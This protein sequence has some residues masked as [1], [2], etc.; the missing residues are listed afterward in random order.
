MRGLCDSLG[1]DREVDTEVA[2]VPWLSGARGQRGPGQAL[3]KET[4]LSAE[5]VLHGWLHHRVESR[6][7]FLSPRQ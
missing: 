2:Q 5:P 4:E 7:K 1:G 6:G 3:E